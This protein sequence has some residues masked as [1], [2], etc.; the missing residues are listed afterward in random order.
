MPRRGE[1]N[2]NQLSP[3]QPSPSTLSPSPVPVPRSA[4]RQSSLGSPVGDEKPRSPKPRKL[5]QMD[6]EQKKSVERPSSEEHE[7]VVSAPPAIFADPPRGEPMQEE[8]LD[9]EE[10]PALPVS[11][12]PQLS[13][14]QT[15]GS[16]PLSTE[17]RLPEPEKSPLVQKAPLPERSPQP[18]RPP[19]VQ[20]YR[21][22]ENKPSPPVVKP[23]KASENPAGSSSAENKTDSKPD[24]LHQATREG[25]LYAVP[26]K[27]RTDEEKPVESSQPEVHHTEANTGDLYAVPEKPRTDEEKPVES[28]QPEVHH[29]EANTGD[30]YA[31][32]ERTSSFR[33]EVKRDEVPPRRSGLEQEVP[34][35]PRSTRPGKT[36]AGYTGLFGDIKTILIEKNGM[37]LGV[38]VTGGANT[39]QREVR[40]KEIVVSCCLPHVKHCMDIMKHFTWQ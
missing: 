35:E 29:T 21:A 10:P 32:P 12:P 1:S 9:D 8:E 19:V 3:K 15:A 25:D 39:K 38:A 14:I 5:S 17:R 11:S 4:S 18:Q 40:I 13:P 22:S 26:E 28:S 23:Y 20:P 2:Q 27:P 30:L 36:Y 33:D 7:E 37:R 31:V 6:D 24:V 16:E 34:L